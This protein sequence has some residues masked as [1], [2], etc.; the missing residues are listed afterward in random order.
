M[1]KKSSR[2]LM[3]AIALLAGCIKNSI[4]ENSID[5]KM[6]AWNKNQVVKF[7]IPVNDTVNGYKISLNI[8][9]NNE[10]PYSNL[11]LF[12]NSYAPN[13]KSIKDTIELTIADDR[14]K[15]LGK[16]FGGVWNNEVFLGNGATI[17]FPHAGKYRIE[18]IHAMRDDVLKGI[19]DVGLKVKKV[20]E[21]E[22]N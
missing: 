21:T 11:F 4:Y 14:G 16:G 3:F 17:R 5:I 15:W 12:V 6:G 18:V 7:E 10:Y 13:G 9:N 22:S 20:E 8:R 1:M 2:I 19:M